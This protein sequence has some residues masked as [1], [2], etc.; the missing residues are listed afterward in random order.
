MTTKERTKFDLQ[1][2]LAGEPV[3]TRDGRRVLQLAHFP[4]LEEDQRVIVALD[5]QTSTDCYYEN[6]VYLPDKESPYDLFMAPKTKKLWIA[7]SKNQECGSR[8][9]SYAYEN[10]E[11]MPNGNFHIIQIEVEE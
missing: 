6:G 11:D 4:M 1:R 3:E 8:G 5:G 2:A 9:T 10:K 7:V